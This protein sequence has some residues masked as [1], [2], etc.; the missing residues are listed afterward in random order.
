MREILKQ[1]LTQT[2]TAKMQ[3]SNIH[4]FINFYQV[5]IAGPIEGVEEARRR[6]RVSVHCNRNCTG[7]IFMRLKTQFLHSGFFTHQ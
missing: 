2:L 5:S 6:I 1:L 7:S 4:L 3:K